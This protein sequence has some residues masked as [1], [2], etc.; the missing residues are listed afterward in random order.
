MIDDETSSDPTSQDLTSEGIVEGLKKA[1]SEYDNSP[2]QGVALALEAVFSHL[3]A[4][5]IPANLVEPLY[6]LRIALDDAQR[7]ASNALL[8]VQKKGHRPPLEI[9]ELEARAHAAAA[10]E[11]LIRAGETPQQAGRIVFRAIR[12]W[13]WRKKL[14]LNDKVALKWREHAMSGYIGE[15]YDATTYYGL[16]EYAENSEIEIRAIATTL[17][18]APPWLQ[19]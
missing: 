11:L 8:S 10:L 15:D 6:A 7:G 18:S 5:D 2:R 4:I 19:Q 16:I 12:S 13:P 17:L 3:E 9:A 1:R 14:N